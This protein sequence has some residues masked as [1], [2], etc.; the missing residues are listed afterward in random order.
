MKHQ[1]QIIVQI[2]LQT[3]LHVT[4]FLS[5]HLHIYTYMN[6]KHPAYPAGTNAIRSSMTMKC[7]RD[8]PDKQLSNMCAFC[9]WI[10]FH[11]SILKPISLVI[12]SDPEGSSRIHALCNCK[13][14][15]PAT[16]AAARYVRGLGPA[17]IRV[18]RRF[19][20]AAAAGN[21]GV[22]ALLFQETPRKV[23]G[24]SYAM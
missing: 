6:I 24:W 22:P 1:E 11:A 13:V 8:T 18:H 21:A 7:F 23:K 19:L 20:A 12:H 15:Q 4:I 9:F 14:S 16:V 17:I 2:H 10:W 5:T 3:P